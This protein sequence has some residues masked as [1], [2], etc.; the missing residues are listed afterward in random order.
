MKNFADVT[1]RIEFANFLDVPLKKLTYVLYSKQCENLYISFEIPKK[2]GNVRCINAPMNDLKDIQQ[3]LAKILINHQQNIRNENNISPNISHAF[4]KNKSIITNAK[5]HRNKRFVFNT[6]LKD[7]FDHFHFGRVCG[8]FE[9]NRHFQFPKEIAVIIAQLACYKGS[10]PQG[11][12]TS[13]IITNLI[14]EILDFRLLKLA[15]EYK[16]D[17]T[18]YADDL[19]FST[20]NPSFED[21]FASF[22]YK[23]QLEIE[24]A[25]F[26]INDTKSRLQFRDS[27]Q[28]VTG[29]IVNK[30]INTK[31]EYSKNTR[32][33]ARQ[34]Y[35]QGFFTINNEI[36]TINQLEGRFSFINQ[37]DL[38]NNRIDVNIGS[39]KKHDFWNLSSRERQYQ[40]FLFYKYFFANPKPFIITEGKTD[41]VYIK[42]ALKNLYHEF[43]NLIE[44]NEDDSFMF[45][46]S[47]LRRTKRLSYFLNLQV[48]GADTIKNLYN[49]FARD[50]STGGKYPCYFE[51]LKRM[52][53]NIPPNNPV[54]FL[55]D[56]EL[57]NP[58]KPLAN[59]ANCIKLNDQKKISL[60]NN[61]KINIF[62]NLYLLTHQLINNHSEC[63]IEDLFDTD[64]LNSKI[65]EKSFS[66]K[67][68]FDVNKFYG[69]QIFSQYIEQ[70]YLDI[71]FDN[72]RPLLNNI[73]E[74]IAEY[75]SIN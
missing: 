70:H 12:P 37:I 55:F 6:D 64:T 67:D 62:G 65:D 38:Y 71:N 69:K 42:A 26:K 21:Q 57:S 4:E 49:F 13:P 54:I 28:E 15:K 3:N 75:K 27:R 32:A 74:I 52:N 48:D 56:N 14:C 17:F 29:L 7:F 2:N 19:T 30:K 53:S 35:T 39:D 40:Q 60:E 63:E 18:R 43:P 50:K 10:L 5:I 36:G 22:K 34:L 45:K 16:L 68:S 73:N 46:I 72:F 23:L 59:F 11:A 9:K 20:N 66:R 51:I 44:K 41:P 25:G 33:M 24:H 31:K 1:T 8:F 61:N 58:K 47:F